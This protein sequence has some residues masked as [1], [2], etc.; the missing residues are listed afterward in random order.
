[1]S[2]SPANSSPASLSM[3]HVCPATRLL[4]KRR[5]MFEVQESLDKQ[6]EIFAKQ[7]VCVSLFFPLYPG[8]RL[9]ILISLW[10]FP[11][12][13]IDHLHSQEAFRLR[14]EN[15]RKHD[16]ELQNSLVKF[17]KFLQENEAKRNRATKRYEEECKIRKTKEKEAEL[18]KKELE[19]GR[20]E[21]E[22]LKHILQDRKKYQIYLDTVVDHTS[23]EY[24]EI[25]ELLSR[26]R[27]LKAA[28]DD[29]K[30][31]AEVTSKSIDSIR[32]ELRHFT[33][34]R[35]TEI[36]QRNN[37]LSKLRKAIDHSETNRIGVQNEMNATARSSSAKTMLLEEIIMAV[38][39]L[40]QRCT[41][42]Y[43]VHINHGVAAE[44]RRGGKSSSIDGVGETKSHSEKALRTVEN[45]EVIMRYVLDFK[46]I[47]E[48][49]MNTSSR[50]DGSNSVEK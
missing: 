24:E 43:G 13:T 48:S 6:Q 1:M 19:R 3:D 22:K 36:L 33:K 20:K 16:L 26:Y 35:T 47:V 34:E 15:L 5:M 31:R 12:P 49:S 28:Q 4:E 46:K 18:L 21:I 41:S 7:Q 10:L 39:N 50:R 29:L 38:D 17:N 23:E 40:K 11:Y 37:K 30:R 44:K 45:L 42:K 32:S 9:F 25:G 14:E 27:T 8:I 2:T